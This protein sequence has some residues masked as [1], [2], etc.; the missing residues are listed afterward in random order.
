MG[1]DGEDADATLVSRMGRGDR[2]ALAELYQRHASRV[3]AVV[4]R[5]LG[6]RAAAEDLVHDVF[7]EAWRRSSDYSTE[8]G[9]V[10]TWLLLRARSRAIDRRRAA[11]NRK[12]SQLTEAILAEIADPGGDLARRSD[13][14]KLMLALQSMSQEEQQVIVLGYFEGLSSSEIAERVG[15]PVGTVKSRTRTALIRLRSWF[16]EGAP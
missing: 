2:A 5:I 1:S 7:V 9:S 11:S 12:T 4:Q 8:R 16:A 6:D 10:I 13:H 3:L 14:G 15:S